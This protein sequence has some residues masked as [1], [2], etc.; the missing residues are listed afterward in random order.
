MQ[1]QHFVGGNY[2]ASKAGLTGISGAATT[3]TT[4]AAL[5][6]AIG[7]KA[8]S[9]GAIAGGAT[10]TVDAVTGLPITIPTNKGTNVLWCVDAAGNVRLVQGSTE[11]FDGTGFKTAPPQFASLPDTLTPFA[12]SV[13][14]NTGAPFTIGV[15]L[16][17]Q[18]GAAHAV[19]DVLTVPS[20]PQIA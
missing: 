6:Y 7:G 17:N 19:Q 3:M 1:S 4:A 15:S 11:D 2:S 13:H 16:W 18:A 20:R 9:R 12:Y 5:L 8:Y 14:T 10:P